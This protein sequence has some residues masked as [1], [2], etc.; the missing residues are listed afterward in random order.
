[1]ASRINYIFEAENKA[2]KL[3]AQGN[4]VL[5]GV[6]LPCIDFPATLLLRP[7]IRYYDPVNL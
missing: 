4:F 7:P 1:M 6:W 5:I 3:K 2:E